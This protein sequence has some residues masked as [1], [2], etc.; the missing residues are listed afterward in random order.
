MERNQRAP[1]R[2]FG[3]AAFVT[4]L[5]VVVL[6]ANFAVSYLNLRSAIESQRAVGTA[7]ERLRAISKRLS[8]VQDAESGERGFLVTGDPRYLKPYD[9]ALA[10]INQ[11]RHDLDALVAGQPEL[12]EWNE[13]FDRH[14]EAELKELADTIEIR[15]RDG[16]AAA[17]AA[18]R[19]GEGERHMDAIRNI[20][21][22]MD[23]LEADHRAELQKLVQRNIQFSI[24]LMFVSTIFGLSAI[25]LG[26]Y[27]IQREIMARGRFSEALE[28]ADRKKND[29]L[30]LVG[31][32]LRNPLAAI[33]NA[34]D[35]LHML[36]N[37]D[38]TGEEM[39]AI[40]NRQI[41]FMSRLVNDLL[42]TARVAHG[43]LE[44][45][46]TRLDLT[47]LLDR[48]VTDARSA[49]Q[50]VGV[51]IELEVPAEPVWVSGDATRLSQVVGNLVDNAVK[52]SPRHGHVRV[53]LQKSQEKPQQATISVID[54]GVGMDAEMLQSV[55]EPFVQG[56]AAGDRDRRG[57]GLGL[58]L[59]RGL[60]EL[61]GGQIMAHSR[62]AGHG[63][64]MSVTLP[65]DSTAPAETE[66]CPAATAVNGRCRVVVI[67]DRRDARYALQRI[68]EFSGHEVHVAADGPHGIELACTVRPD[69]V[70]CD[71]G[72]AGDMSGYDVVRQL[73]Q[74]PET[75]HSHVVA[76]TGYGQDEVRQRA[77]EAGFHR[78]LIKPV[79]LA[80]LSLIIAELPCNAAN[81]AQTAGSAG[82]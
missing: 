38:E 67:D 80:A 10:Q 54:Q 35:V 25:G 41:V 76:V 53:R 46:K 5:L 12:V 32:E 44:L 16:A 59:A 24:V 82:K 68:L 63:T 50:A 61:H 6:L 79:S 30:A 43:K 27:L 26:F 4:V 11:T 40:I 49:M 47:E 29:F 20:T 81:H 36:G 77:T 60:V 75:S 33:T 70:L 34:A 9:A 66:P 28:E 2:L 78:H 19:A 64:T 51:G 58:A 73:R 8:V 7:D 39:R 3:V 13:Q 15:R 74:L 45:R 31:H 71:I 37:L 42:D 56:V 62:G 22:K 48:T 57:L 17:D 14:V 21:A 65:L 1:G 18:V 52:F 55:F 23:G 72:L 69:L